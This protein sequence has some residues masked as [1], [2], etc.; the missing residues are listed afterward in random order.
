MIDTRLILIE[1]VPCSGKSTTAEI[2]AKDISSE[3]IQ[4]NCF[5]EWSEDNPIFIGKMENLAEII[6]TTK[7]RE[8]DVFRQWTNFVHHARQHDAINIIESRFWQTNGMYLYLSGHSE[9]DVL[10][11]T[12]QLTSIIVELNPVL[13]YLAPADIEA[14]HAHVAR[15]KN[16]KWR[17]AGREGSWE[18][19]GNRIYEQQEWFTRRSLTSKAMAR[20]FD[21]W[22]AITDRLFIEFPFGKIKIKDP[23]MDWERTMDLISDFI[24]INGD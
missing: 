2:L 7:A 24:G 23:Q 13:I 17:E 18:E 14:L 21:E 9:E 10:K 22:A 3:G 1:G 15:E 6:S 12:S 11:S 16:Q 19:W 8:T 5:L 4:V 20:F